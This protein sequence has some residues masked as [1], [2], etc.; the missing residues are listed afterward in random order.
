[1][2]R[3]LTGVQ[4]VENRI[5]ERTRQA[6]QTAVLTRLLAR[7]TIVRIKAERAARLEKK[8]APRDPR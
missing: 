5:A 2:S 1:M 3:Y 4:R 6:R 8:T 7:A